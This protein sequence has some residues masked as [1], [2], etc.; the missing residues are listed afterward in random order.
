MQCAD[1][2]KKE[3]KRKKKK[4]GPSFAYAIHTMEKQ[5]EV[6]VSKK[7]KKPVAKT[8]S[9]NCGWNG[10]KGLFVWLYERRPSRM[11][12]V[13]ALTGML[14]VGSTP[15]LGFALCLILATA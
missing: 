4:K 5:P 7:E 3:K 6:S 2:Q 14:V 8:L 9:Q 15:T 12:W 10:F 1:I 11:L 13:L